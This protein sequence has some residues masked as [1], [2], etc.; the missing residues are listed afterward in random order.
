[1]PGAIVDNVRRTKVRSEILRMQEAQARLDILQ[2]DWQDLLLAHL[3]AMY[4]SDV[5]RRRMAQFVSTEHNPLKR[6]GTELSTA[7]KWGATRVLTDPG[8]QAIAEKL[9]KES[10]IDEVMASVDLHTTVLRDNILTPRIIDGRMTLIQRLPNATTIVQHP[11]RPDEAVAMRTEE[12]LAHTAGYTAVRQ[13]YADVERWVEKD[14]ATGAIL[15]NEAHGLG[16]FPGVVIHADERTEGYFWGT[17]AFR[18][19]AEATLGIGVLLFELSRLTHFQSELQPVFRGKAKDIGKGLTIG[20]EVV[21]AGEGEWDT[22]DLQADPQKILSVIRARLGWIASQYG[23]A[24]DVYDLSAKPTSGFEI[25]LRRAP[26]EALRVAALKRWRRVEHDLLKLMAM[27][28]RDHPLYRL[29]PMRCEFERIDFHE[30]PMLEDPSTQDRIWAE[31]L[32]LGVL[33]EARIVMEMNPDLSLEQAQAYVLQLLAEREPVIAQK[34]RL[35]DE[36]TTQEATG[37]EGGLA[38]ARNA[39]EE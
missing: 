1:M 32:K 36:E 2:D 4:E 14:A 19:V 33:S 3:W 25:R 30:E 26:I 11:R 18:D 28:S 31:R 15:I 7:Y 20:G 17:T 38:K 34:K 8:Q 22:L 21:W 9:W 16:R 10:R 12:G 39:E 24:A 35:G 29:D 27:V 37:R 13:I 6:I 5:I 23:L